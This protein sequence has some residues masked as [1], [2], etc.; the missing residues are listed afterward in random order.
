MLSRFL[1][2]DLWGNREFRAF[3]A[4]NTVERFA[5]SALTVMLAFHVYEVRK[6]PLDIALLGIV[7]VIPAL[8][9]SLY[10][11][12][13]ADRYSRRAIVLITVGLLTC[14]CGG[15]VLVSLSGFGLLAMLLLAAFLSA[16]VRAY[17]TPAAVGLEAQILPV[18]QVLRGVPIIS[19]SGRVA[20][21]VGPVVM[22][23]IWSVSG[24]AVSYG[25]LCG[26]FVATLLIFATGIGE[27]PVPQ[28]QAG[29]PG[30]LTRIYEGVKFVFSNQV[31]I[32]S[33]A[34]D[35]FAVFFG[36]AAALLPVFATDILNVGPSGFG[37]LRAAIAAGALAAAI[38]SIRY[39]PKASAGLTL[40]LIIGGFGL[41]M[42]AFGLSTNFYL[43]MAALFVA[44]VCDG[45]SMVIRH[46]ILRLASP[47]HMRGRIAAVRMV[48]VSS[49]N[50]LGAV[51]MGL[52]ATALGPVRAVVAGGCLTMLVV[53]MVAW[54]APILR[55]L[56]LGTYNANAP[57]P[58]IK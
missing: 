23:F 1:K 33:M 14:I 13:V 56:D 9:L 18:A 54:R 51:Q 40:H 47:E 10:G 25:V 17:E 28:R 19:T 21:M 53:A 31:L 37:L 22:G 42:I 11:G 7:Q 32:G 35:L 44:G 36:G 20:D 24:A 39:M 15:L 5:A 27:K 48:F 26:L 8:T 34:L 57:L 3:V 4:A 43:S 30:P 41:S 29:G 12:D 6:D 38:V 58:Q 50:E 16:S 2:H 52:S 46:A 45:L 49:S 55:R